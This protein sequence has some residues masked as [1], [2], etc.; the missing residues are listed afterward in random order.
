MVTSFTLRARIAA[1]FFLLV[2]ALVGV[3]FWQVLGVLQSTLEEQVV[4]R[5]D[6]MLDVLKDAALQVLTTGEF[7]GLPPQ[8]LKSH[9]LQL[10]RNKH[11]QRAVLTD[12]HGR[13]I[14]ASD[15]ADLGLTLRQLKPPQGAYW[16]TLV[17]G[18]P[19]ARAGTLALEFAHTQLDEVRED[20]I[21]LGIAIAA[22]CMILITLVG[23]AIG[24]LLTRRIYKLREAAQQM[25]EGDLTVRTGLR[26]KDEVAAVSRAFDLMAKRVAASQYEMM[27][28]NRALE[29]RVRQRTLELTNS[30][31]E[32]QR[33][34]DKLVQSEKLAALGALVAGVSHEINTPLGISVTAATYVEELF[35]ALEERLRSGR[36][37]REYLDEFIVRATE[38]NAM[39]LANLQRAAELIRNFKMVA[40][41]QASAKRREFMLMETVQEIVST[42]RPLLKNR[43]VDLVLDLPD[44]IA[45]DSYPGPL[46]QVITNLFSNALLHAFDGRPAGCITIR[47]RTYADESV[48]LFFSDDGVGVSPEHLNRIFD[49]FFTTKSGEGGSGLGLSIAYNIVTGILGGTI[50]V[51]SR[52]GEGTTF[53]VTMPRVAPKV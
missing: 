6:L 8:L 20:A 33:M 25:A 51:E 26:G 23:L 39:S 47:A 9:F 21:S 46:G 28:M 24:W 35:K 7:D 18:N 10:Q 1:T 36:F 52:P 44:G 43:G 19:K 12:P 11:I 5:E 53:T 49:P 48:S 2:G 40:V 31:E 3:A 32:M 15:A 27:R 34:Q 17:I 4:A 41:D 37:T 45:M 29:H 22:T 30:V 16:R 38:A 50:T 13:V 42:L 14:V